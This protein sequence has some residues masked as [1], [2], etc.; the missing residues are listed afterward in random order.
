MGLQQD[1]ASAEAYIARA[2]RR[3]GKQR[4]LIDRSR[5]EQT[6]A[7][8]RDL[9]DIL[10]ALLMNVVERQQGRRRHL[11]GVRSEETAH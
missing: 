5:N 11:G 9:V 2:N 6:V 10:S 1:I 3:I 4:H 8:A 7:T